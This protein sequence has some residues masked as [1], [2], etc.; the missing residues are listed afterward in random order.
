[1]CVSDAGLDADVLEWVANAYL[2]V[3][4]GLMLMKLPPTRVLMYAL[5]LLVTLLLLL[6][7]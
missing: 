3:S 2:L 5:A 6:P 1:M 4:S 7:L